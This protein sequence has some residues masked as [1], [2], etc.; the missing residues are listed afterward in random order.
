MACFDQAMHVRRKDTRPM[1]ALRAARA[2][3]LL[4]PM[5]GLACAADPN[6]AAS[7]SG[8]SAETRTKHPTKSPSISAPWGDLTPPPPS[9]LERR[10]ANPTVAD[11]LRL[12]LDQSPRIAAAR[13]RALAAGEESAIEGWLPNPELSIGWYETSVQ[14]RVGSQEW[15]VGIR[16]AIPFPTKLATRA[17][18]EDSEAREAS[19]AYERAARD[20]AVDVVRTAYELAYLE[21]ALA[22]TGEIEALLLRYA[23]Y[24]AGGDS[25]SQVSEL[26]RAESQRAQLA[27]DRVLLA[28]LRSVEQQRMK[29]LV[30]LPDDVHIGAPKVPPTPLVKSTVQ[31]LLKVAGTQNQEL[32]QADL[33]VETAALRTSLAKQSRLPDLSIGL[34]HIETDELDPALGM[35]PDGNGDDPLILQLGVSLPIWVQR[36]SAVI[37]RAE[38]M[39]YA[40][41]RDREEVLLRTKS[42]VAEAYYRVGNAERLVQLYADVLIPRAAVAARTAEDLIGSGK[43]TLGGLLETI[44]VMHNFRL[45]EARARADLGQAFSALERVLGQPFEWTGGAP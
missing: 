9:D 39:Q 22:I 42:Q 24:A 28:E 11:L 25:G 33:A 1:S 3:L 37:R 26:F 23:T 15:S 27:N 14:T 45:A 41:V 32:R 19:V 8:E 43:G 6:R 16:Q 12:A 38:A 7:P 35:D 5:V 29:S 40:A 4:A 36:D 30:A 44:A 2:L 31:D 17:S 10:L 34:T 13:A 18:I 21:E 20:V